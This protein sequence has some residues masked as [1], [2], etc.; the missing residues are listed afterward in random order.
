M[1]ELGNAFVAQ[2]GLEQSN[3]IL[4]RWMA[5]HLA[6]LIEEAKAATGEEKNALEQKC[7][8]AILAVWKHRNCL[9]Q[10]YR[11]FE[12]A[13]PLLDTVA[14]LDPDAPKPFYS[15]V[16]LQWDDL[17][18]IDRPTESEARRFDVVRQFDRSAR[19]VIRHLIGRAV[20]D[21][22]DDTRE[23]IRRAVGAGLKGP[24]IIVLRRL[25]SSVTPE[26]ID[27]QRLSVEIRQHRI[28]LDELDMFLGIA[29]QVREDIASR[30]EAA[31]G[32]SAGPGIEA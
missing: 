19:T 21:L 16:M 14:A 29:S 12:A 11:P 25:L 22:P 8:D 10:G 5:H 23:W 30:L 1:I 13:E 3:D 24:D 7:F 2:L 28:M 18:E 17:D 31:E 26:E 9:P 15:R 32:R 20:E 27:Q 6:R 4:G